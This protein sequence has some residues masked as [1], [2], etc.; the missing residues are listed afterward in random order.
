MYIVLQLTVYTQN[1]L[2][3]FFNDIQCLYFMNTHIALTLH[4]KLF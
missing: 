3:A 1:Y 2:K 4:Q